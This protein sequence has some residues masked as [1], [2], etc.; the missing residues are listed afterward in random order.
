MSCSVVLIE[1][2]SGFEELASGEV[3]LVFDA[4]D[5]G[6]F[7]IFGIRQLRALRREECVLIVKMVHE[8]T[9]GED[10]AAGEVGLQ[11]G[12]IAEAQGVIVVGADGQCGVDDVVV[13]AVEGVVEPDLSLFDRTGEGEAGE[14][15]VEAPSVLV[16]DGGNEVGGEEAEVIVAD[17]GVEAEDAAGSFAVFGGLARRLDLNGAE[18]VGADADA[19]VV[20]W[21]VG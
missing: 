21:R 2:E 9:G 19:G 11:F 17:A 12:E 20:R 16:L 6:G 4:G 1:G 10:V 7:D 14:E 5:V 13:F 3:V 18:G 15:L 8:K